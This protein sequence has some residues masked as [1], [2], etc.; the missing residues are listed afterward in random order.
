MFKNIRILISPI[1]GGIIIAIGIVGFLFLVVNYSFK[2]LVI[3]PRD[4]ANI[5][6]VAELILIVQENTNN[7]SVDDLDSSFQQFLVDNPSCLN[8]LQRELNV[9]GNEY[10]FVVG[11]SG[12]VKGI[13]KY[14]IDDS[15][16]WANFESEA[17]IQFSLYQ[18]DL[19][20]CEE[21]SLN[22]T[23]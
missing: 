9:E 10:S 12:K 15:Y 8:V 2:R 6:L 23:N 18:G 1:L 22:R 14:F 16:V 4:D 5:N 11:D 17:V 7:I 19:V 13:R 21:M 3:R 20:G